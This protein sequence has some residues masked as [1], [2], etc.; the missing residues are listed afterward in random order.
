MFKTVY[1][2]NLKEHLESTGRTYCLVIEECCLA[3]REKWMDTEGL[4]RLAASSAKLKLLKV[5]G[6]LVTYSE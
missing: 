4:F 2:L 6:T 1:G 3:L 5:S